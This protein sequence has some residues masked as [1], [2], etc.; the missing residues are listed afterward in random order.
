MSSRTGRAEARRLE[1][2]SEGLDRLARQRRAVRFNSWIDRDTGMG[3]WSA[4]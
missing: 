4:M 3:R 1:R 2:D